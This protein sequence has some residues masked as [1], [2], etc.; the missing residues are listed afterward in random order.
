M[1][2]KKIALIGGG[3]IGQILA[4]LASQKELGDVVILDIPQFENPVKGKALDLME[5]RP[6]D[7][8]SV[9]ITGTSDY[10]DISD[11]DVV[12]I[13]AGVPRRPGMS[14]DDLLEINLKIIGDVA[15]NVKKYA[16]DAF[17][18]VVSNPLDAIVYA[19]YKVSGFSKN[20]V[21]GMAGALDS[22]RFKAF[23][24]M[25]TGYSPQD[26]Q[27][28]VLGGH[29]DTMVPLTRLATV[30]GIPV[31]ELLDK[32]TIEGIEQRTRMAGGEIVKLLGNGSAFF[33]PAKS[34]MTM[35]ESYLL[36]QKRIIPSAGLCEGEYGIKDLFIGV[37]CVIG[38]DGI[39]KI[40]E[41]ELTAEEKAALKV[42][43]D[44]VASVVE[45]TGL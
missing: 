8:T 2:R 38:S 14:R 23:I 19:F 16:P 15:E 27:C 21:I 5:M 4:L 25:E 24:A 43:A 22:S 28:L 10:A 18:I 26:V 44:H 11:S 42:T 13:T 34:A 45:E 12:I 32:E 39:E 6:L 40:I 30:G 3:Q 35:A 9:N 20:K 33:S 17:V 7:N 37:P 41:V 29:G 31:T 1:G 36:D